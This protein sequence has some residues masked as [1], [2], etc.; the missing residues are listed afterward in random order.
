VLVALQDGLRIEAEAAAKSADFACP[1]CG[2]TVRVRRRRGYVTHFYHVVLRGCHW[3]N[4]GPEHRSA[5]KLI[6][7]EY[8]RRGF[9]VAFEWTTANERDKN[10][11]N[12][13]ID[14]LPARRT[15]VVIWRQLSKGT[16]SYAVEI[17]DSHISHQEFTC[18][19]EDWE[20]L[21]I[22]VLWLSIPKPDLREHMV[23]QARS[24]LPSRYERYAIRPFEQMIWRRTRELWFIVPDHGV[25]F[26]SI[27][28]AHKIHV[29]RYMGFDQDAGDFFELGG[30][31][32]RSSRFVDLS[33]SKPKQLSDIRIDARERI[34]T[35]Q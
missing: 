4:E 2:R 17:Q 15:D 32:Y 27:V 24:G 18:R 9:E 20:R 1:S 12:A 31:D 29:E 5:K 30:Y 6:G 22:A 3:E 35:W 13:V 10:F 23:A 34:A 26:Q 8:K 16:K 21:G 19:V 33:L 25:L 28:A 14:D 11:P 7:D